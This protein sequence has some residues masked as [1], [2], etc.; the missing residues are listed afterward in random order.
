MWLNI[1]KL[2]VSK[3]KFQGLKRGSVIFF[4]WLQFLASTFYSKNFG[5]KLFFYKFFAPG[6]FGH[7][8]L[9]SRIFS[10]KNVWLLNFYLINFRL[11]SFLVPIL[12]PSFWLANFEPQNFLASE[13]FW[14]MAQ[15]FLWIF[16]SRVFFFY[17]ILDLEFSRLKILRPEIFRL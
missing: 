9:R 11:Q 15:I 1:Q 17:E 5:P 2:S 4:F 13:F 12:C 10:L 14:Q 6:F 8:I 3:K 7:K 16:S